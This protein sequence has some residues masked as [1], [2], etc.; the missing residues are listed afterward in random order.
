M[1]SIVRMQ[2]FDMTT[3]L[4]LLEVITR[5]LVAAQ[6]LFFSATYTLRP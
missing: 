6:V 2:A 3:L 1:N 5:R 4:T